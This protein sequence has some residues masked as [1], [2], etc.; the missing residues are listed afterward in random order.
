MKNKDYKYRY[1]L[2]LT[3]LQM[4]LITYI[5]HISGTGTAYANPAFTTAMHTSINDVVN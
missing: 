1:L 5:Y 3:Y 2:S 4:H